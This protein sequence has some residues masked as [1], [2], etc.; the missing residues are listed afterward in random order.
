[1]RKGIQCLQND[2]RDNLLWTTLPAL[3]PEPQ[4]LISTGEEKVARVGSM[5]FK[6]TVPENNLLNMPP[7]R[8]SLRSLGTESGGT[9][10]QN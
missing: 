6:A 2:F 10:A 4:T 5:I 1:M 3:L 7:H 8:K 9:S